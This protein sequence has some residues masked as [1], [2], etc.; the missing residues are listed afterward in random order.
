VSAEHEHIWPR[1]QAE[2]ARAVDEPTYRLWL[3][4]LR[5]V[6]IDGLHLH[7]EAPANAARWIGERFGRV[8]QSSAEAALGPGASVE[9]TGP[10][11]P[12]PRVSPHRVAGDAA[13]RVTASRTSPTGPPPGPLGN[14]K[15]TFDQFVIGDCN[16]LAH[17]A[18][19]AVA[20]MPAHAYNPLFLCGPP[21]VGQTHLMSAVANLLAAHDPGLAVRCT[22]GEAFTNEFL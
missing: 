8:L 20:E 21:G 12:A 15:L 6:G 11:Q 4:G 19:L 2:I 3:E 17:A 10:A 7:L 13:R 1:V 5:P 22:T 18:A 14:P 9:L 16:R